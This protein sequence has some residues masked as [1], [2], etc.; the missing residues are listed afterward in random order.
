MDERLRQVLMVPF[1]LH[2]EEE[3]EEHIAE[4]KRLDFF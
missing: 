1:H 3:A 4:E 2:R